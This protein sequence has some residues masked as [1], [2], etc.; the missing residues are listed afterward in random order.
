M[1]PQ[2]GC[3]GAAQP[4]CIP[5][6]PGPDFTAKASIAEIK[7]EA[8]KHAILECLN[9]GDSSLGQLPILNACTSR[10]KTLIPIRN[11]AALHSLHPEFDKVEQLCTQLGSTGLYP[12]AMESRAEQAFQARQFPKSSG[13]QE[14]AATGI[15]AAALSFGLLQTGCIEAS[16]RDITVGQGQAM[17]RPSKIHITFQ[18]DA[19]GSVCSCWLGGSASLC[20]D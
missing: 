5:Q 2:W 1:D 16:T 18:L 6:C 8:A 11:C 10:T 4:R 20:T 3:F 14:D 19:T 17:G 9:I 15:A 12:F 7:G 13:Y